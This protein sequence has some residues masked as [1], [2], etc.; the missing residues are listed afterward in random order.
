MRSY[1]FLSP[2]DFETFLPHEL[3]RPEFNL[4]GKE[5]HMEDESKKK[6]AMTLRAPGGLKATIWPNLR[7]D[8]STAFAVQFSRTYRDQDGQF[9]DTSSFDAG[10]A[11]QVSVLATDAY[12]A[13]SQLREN[14]KTSGSEPEPGF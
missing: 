3:S 9:H 6:P 2:I 4:G 13:I 8:G 1:A 10:E 11:L 7:R 5:N 12:K 14:E